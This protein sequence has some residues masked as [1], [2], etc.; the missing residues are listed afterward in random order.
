M[1]LL[2]VGLAAIGLYGVL[3]IAY[4]E[5]A[6]ISACPA[7]GPVPACYVVLLAYAL[8]AASV[9]VGRSGRPV[10]FFAGWIPVFLLASVGSG[11]EVLGREA[12]PRTDGNI[13]TCFLSLA[14]A[15]GLIVAFRFTKPGFDAI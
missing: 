3:P 13:P 9:L 4:R 7:L 6:G 11:L 2:V 14:L 5:A 15:V 8:I 12:C 10:F 1:R